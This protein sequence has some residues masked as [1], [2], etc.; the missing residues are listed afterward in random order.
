VTETFV[1]MGSSKAAAHRGYAE[2]AIVRSARVNAS[3]ECDAVGERQTALSSHSESA[4][5]TP[6]DAAT[7]AK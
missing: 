7:L 6:A 4:W 5:T 1:T 3:A 2:S